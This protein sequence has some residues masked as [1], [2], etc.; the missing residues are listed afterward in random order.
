MVWR[1]RVTRHGAPVVAAMAARRG[2]D[3]RIRGQVTVAAG[4]YRV[5]PASPAFG[6][7]TRGPRG[8]ALSNSSGCQRLGGLV[9]RA[10]ACSDPGH[11]E[12][13]KVQWISRPPHFDHSAI[14]PHSNSPA[15]LHNLL[16]GGAESRR[17][18]PDVSPVPPEPQSASGWSWNNEVRSPPPAALR[19]NQTPLMTTCRHLAS[20]I[21]ADEGTLSDHAARSRSRVNQ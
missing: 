7:P 19:P 6:W 12:G 21:T 13:A 2:R 3:D 9:R 10:G 20:P 16:N 15:I 4:S 17:V 1:R 5:S 8:P 14:P 18:S 11:G